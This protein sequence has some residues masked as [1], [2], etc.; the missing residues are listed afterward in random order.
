M[1]ASSRLLTLTGAGG[2]GKTRLA[3]QVAAEIKESDAPRVALVELAALTDPDLLPQAVA[4]A[5]GIPEQP[6]RP[7]QVVVAD[8]LR[9]Q[10]FVLVLDNC[11]HAS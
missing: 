7:P 4:S 1:L 9:P 10:R 11:E 6:N 3:V 2:I 8:V 5:L